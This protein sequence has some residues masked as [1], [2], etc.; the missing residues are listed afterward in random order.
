MEDHQLYMQLE[1]CEGGSLG[2]KLKRLRDF[3]AAEEIKKTKKN[4]RESNNSFTPQQ[5]QQLLSAHHQ[6]SSSGTN[7]TEE[8]VGPFPEPVLL[9]VAL[10]MGQALAFLH[11]HGLVHLDVKPDNMLQFADNVFKLADFGL[12]CNYT[13]SAAAASG[14]AAGAGVS[15]LSA[16]SSSP[17]PQ[18]TPEVGDRRYLAPEA[19]D[20]FVGCLP[21]LDCFALGCSLYELASG[22]PFALP[23]SNLAMDR[24]RNGDIDDIAPPRLSPR[25]YECIR[26]LLHPDPAQRM[27][28][29]QLVDDI[30]EHCF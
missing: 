11:A 7:G 15:G 18:S 3:G 13:S 4:A 2:A 10:Q 22:V 28:A 16:S 19:L 17:S 30:E 25:L 12:A 29:Q 24:L 20:E 26:T 14:A 9:Q 23:M 6:S 8:P 5:P 21:A 1:Y 27:T